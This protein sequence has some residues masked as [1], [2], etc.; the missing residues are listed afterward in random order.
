MQ[1]LSGYQR[2]IL[3]KNPNVEKIT[4]KHVQYSSKFKIRAVERYLAGESPGDI[5]KNEGIDPAFFISRYCNYCLK[6]W[7]KKYIEEGKKS[8]KVSQTGKKAT[9]RPKLENP[10]ELTIEELRALVEI[11][12]E[13]IV[14][15]KKN[16]ALTKLKKKK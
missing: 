11:Q 5:F 15:L 7:K 6:R 3:L 1:E 9:G 14:M 2:R 12:Q 10:D 8:L 16:R 4:E 13:V